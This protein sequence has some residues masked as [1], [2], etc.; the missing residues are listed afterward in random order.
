MTNEHVPCVNAESD[1]NHQ[2]RP[3]TLLGPRL[4]YWCVTCVRARKKGQKVKRRAYHLERT[5]GLSTEDVAKIRATMPVNAN[6]V[7]VCPGCRRATGA[8]RA[9]AADHDHAKER[10]GF[11]PRETVRGFLCGPCNRVIGLYGPAALRRLADYVEDP[12]APRALGLI[13]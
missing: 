5:F 8:R 13:S 10:L 12:P 7:R 1:K 11:P 3:T 6:G 2:K 9:L 4:G